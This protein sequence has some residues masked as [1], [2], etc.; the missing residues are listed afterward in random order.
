MLPALLACALLLPAA[1]EAT[2]VALVLKVGGAV[3]LQRGEGKGRLAPGDKLLPGDRLLVPEGGEAVLVYFGDAHRERVKPGA[4][5]TVGKD[6]CGPRG[7]AER[8][9]G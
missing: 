8:V 9:R 3:T 5:A 1:E 6:T 7:A 2:P 4:T